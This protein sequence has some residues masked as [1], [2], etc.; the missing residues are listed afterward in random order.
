MYCMCNTDAAAI[1]SPVQ[2]NA[3]L[4]LLAT[5]KRFGRQV[6][7]RRWHW[8]NAIAATTAAAAAA[9]AAAAVVGAVLT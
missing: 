9:T 8:V 3:R 1:V 4:Y 2:C 7:T 5:A 6:C